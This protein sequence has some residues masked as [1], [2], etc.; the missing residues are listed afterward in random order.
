MGLIHLVF[1]RSPGLNQ[2][3][4]MAMRRSLQM[5]D[6]SPSQYLY[7]VC[8]WGIRSPCTHGKWVLYIGILRNVSPLSPSTVSNVDIDKDIVLPLLRPVISS[9]SLLETSNVASNLV[10]T[11]VSTFLF[12]SGEADCT[13]LIR[14]FIIELRAP[15][16]EVGFG[17]HTKV[18]SQ[19]DG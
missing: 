4:P 15:H 11:E 13:F 5:S 8:I 6:L 18:G 17:Y 16:R 9:M 19:D 3:S 7:L 1:L 14:V 10:S 12:S 2:A